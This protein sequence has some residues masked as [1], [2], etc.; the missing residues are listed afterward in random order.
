VIARLT[1]MLAAT[2]LLVNGGL[3]VTAAET[4]QSLGDRSDGPSLVAVV[5]GLC[6]TSGRFRLTVRHNPHGTLTVG[7]SAHRLPGASKWKIGLASG[8]LTHPNV[9]DIRSRHRTAQGDA[10]SAAARLKAFHDTYDGMFAVGP[11]DRQCTGF[12][13]PSWPKSTV[14]TCHG[15]NGLVM[16]ARRRPG[17]RLAIRAILLGSRPGA[18]W[19][20]STSVTTHTR[21]PSSSQGATTRVTAGR[22]GRVHTRSLFKKVP[23]PQLRI[24]AVGPRPQRCSTSL[25]TTEPQARDSRGPGVSARARRPASSPRPVPRDLGR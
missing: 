5:Q 6:A 8:S 17:D 4:A 10:W 14:T 23:H 19:T 15:S 9:S 3:T 16:L 2:A 7:A 12:V 13:H 24:S 21:T 18:A 11:H 25:R 20:V 22:H 1:G